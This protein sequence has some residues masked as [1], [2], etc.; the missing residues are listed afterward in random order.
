MRANRPAKWA[1]TAGSIVSLTKALQTFLA[2]PYCPALMS[3]WRNA[4]PTANIRFGSTLGALGSAD[5]EP[6]RKRS[7]SWTRLLVL[8]PVAGGDD[9]DEAG[10]ALGLWR[11]LARGQERLGGLLGGLVLVAGDGQVEQLGVD[12]FGL[13]LLELRREA[14][15]SAIL[16]FPARR[17]SARSGRSAPG[18]SRTC[19]SR[20]EPRGAGWW[21]SWSW[22]CVPPAPRRPGGGRGPRRGR[23]SATVSSGSLQPV[24]EDRGISRER[25]PSPRLPCLGSSFFSFEA[26]GM[27]RPNR[28]RS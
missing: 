11:P 25:A 3:L 28:G 22:S 12:R 14:P 27:P 18:G 5:I 1:L 21:S 20:S 4:S 6:L 9:V 17:T 24:Q 16:C 23:R 2:A 8:A 13:G 26:N 10:Q 7:R 15:R 19:C